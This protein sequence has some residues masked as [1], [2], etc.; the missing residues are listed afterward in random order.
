MSL[1]ERI[2]RNWPLK[3]TSVLLSM[4]LWVVAATEE[5]GS[6]VVAAR[7]TL[8]PPPGRTVLQAPAVVS[9]HLT[10]PRRELLKLEASGIVLSR[11]LPDTVTG[12]RVTITLSPSDVI[13]PRGIDVRVQDLEPREVTVELDSVVTR[14]VPVHADVTVQSDRG[15]GLVGGIQVVPGRVLISGPAELVTA[16][17]S[18]ST[19]PLLLSKADG[20]VE[21]RIN[22]D[23]SDLGPIRVI[24]SEVTLTIDV[25]EVSELTINAVPIR[26]PPSLSN[27]TGDLDSVQVIVRGSAVRLAEFNAESLRVVADP[28]A[29]PEHG[30]A[31]GMRVPLRVAAP[32]G[33][34][35]EANPDTV[36]L[37]KKSRGQP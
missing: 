15:L 32:K 4:L 34:T 12:R 25:E 6:R 23:T 11:F 1:Q 14:R 10:G 24:P 18:V 9:L 30:A 16:R 5:P 3:V 8:E 20:E 27:F 19:I 17:E 33:I 7:L 37:M 35:G 2:F 28:L 13:V 22:I 21:R 26:F 31:P 36:T 29:I